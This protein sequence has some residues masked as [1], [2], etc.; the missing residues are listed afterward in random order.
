MK[1]VLQ[2]A[3]TGSIEVAEVPPPRVL[4]GCVL[5]RIAASLVSAGTE[6]A[7]SEFASKN[8][9]QKAKSRPDLV[10]DAI[11]K[12]RRDGLFSAISAVR[13]RLDQP[14]A[15][16]Y[17]SAGTIIEVGDGVSDLK[18]GDRVACAGATFA[19]HAECACVPRLL[20]A[21]IPAADVDFDSAA[22]ATVG[23]VAI[24]GVRTAEAKIGEVV[25]VIG[26]G[27]LGQLSVQI[28][29][30]AGCRVIVIDPVQS[31]A[32]LAARS[33]ALA[34]T[35][36]EA[37]FRDL[38]LAHSGGK[39]LDSVLITAET[40]SS[41]PV[42]L[43]SQV[44]R[45]RGVVVAVGTVGMELQRKLYYEKEIDF[46]VSRSYG[47]GRYD[48]AYEQKGRD[49][50]IGYVRWTETRNMEAFLQL[51][52]DRKLN[53][54]PLITHSFDIETAL[55]AYSLITG[56]KA[57][58]YLGV[59]I[60]YPEHSALDKSVRLELVTR[61]RWASRVPVVKVG[62]LGAG[63]FAQSTLL[64]AMKSDSGTDLIG[65]CAS[66]GARAKATAAKFGFSCCTC[67]E[68]AIVSDPAIN[69][70]V[71]TTRH[72]LHA[73]Q[74]IRVLQAGKHVFCEKPLC[75][76]EQELE[77]IRNVY[78]HTSN[79]LLMVGFNRRFAPMA[80]EM[81]KFLGRP[82]SPL[83]MNY[84]VNAGA[85]PK[86]H[87]INDSEQGGGRIIGEVCHFVDFLSFLCGA[88]PVKVEANGFA[89]SEDQNAVISLEFSDGSLGTIHY[90][91]NGDRAFSK[92]R[93]EVFGNGCVAV[94]DDFRRLDLVRHGRKRS[95]RSWLKQDKGH[96][97]EWQAFA[98]SI[99]MG[100]PV[101]ISFEE[102]FST[103][104]ATFRIAECLRS[105]R[106]QQIAIEPAELL[107]PPLVS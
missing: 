53:I 37:E 100:G 96:V 82:R 40:P 101:P 76:N 32:D 25:G 84:R 74:V 44:A 23:A 95:I 17:S 3:R 87:W 36:L 81:K 47:P 68:D 104:L 94:L 1:Q 69:T 19:V 72:H 91:C 5:V 10:M 13:N 90:A 22:F 26:A 34:A 55:D 43:A 105:G 6:R 83:I 73:A 16:G 2:S 9:L 54:R 77:A 62:L 31:R 60:R 70:L 52:A 67:D 30:A 103:T 99:R 4:P 98:E 88:P 21:R 48:D 7:S 18:P 41:G 12:V 11:A 33:G 45:D 65:L 107:A 27:L 20:V 24:H 102:I 64:P 28:L 14:Q 46:R 79:L 71:I 38:S 39:G 50:P 106:E 75:L 89:S 8:L 63:N 66:S 49:Y 93:V 35:T 59:L 29:N 86:D 78:S 57:E 56:G 15:L 97:A 61:A 58:P 92:E 80:P 51:L 85:L 42:N